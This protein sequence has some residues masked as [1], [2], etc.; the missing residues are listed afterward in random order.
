MEISS[1]IDL[2]LPPA[3]NMPQQEIKA[4]KAPDCDQDI[5]R[6]EAILAGEGP[7]QP[8][9]LDL[10]MPAIEPNAIQN[11][12]QNILD[13]VTQFKESSDNSMDRI[14]AKM[15]AASDGDLDFGDMINFQI[16]CAKFTIE[17]SLLTKSGE[18]AGEGIK[19]LFRN[20]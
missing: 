18:K 3:A 11:V 2:Y 16:E 13:K 1:L 5:Q 20:Q 8:K 12:S 14:N 19:T 6:F 10:V 17:T 7:Y 15:D 4:M 9:S